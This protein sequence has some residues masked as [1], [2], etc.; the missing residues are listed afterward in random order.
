[1]VLFDILKYKGI[2]GIKIF[3][4]K[5][6]MLVPFD[7]VK[8]KGFMGIKIFLRQNLVFVPFWYNKV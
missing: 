7:M 2:M 6:L 8:Y 1:M 3:L 5:N 4:R